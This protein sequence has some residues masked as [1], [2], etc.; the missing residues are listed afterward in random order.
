MLIDEV[1]IKVSAGNG[2]NGCVAFN[3]NLMS[4]GPV[5]ARGGN[6]GSVYFEGVSDLSALSQFRYKKEVKGKNGEDGRGQFMDGAEAGDIVLKVPMGTVITNL[7]RGTKQ[8]ITRVGQKILITKGGRGGRGNFHFKSPTN[9]TP[10]EFEYG[11][12]GQSFTLKLEMKMIADVGLVGLPNV[13]KSSLLNELT[14]AK[15]KVA[16]YHFTTL[17]PYLGD[18]FGLIIADI[19]G[20]IEGAASGKGLGDKFLKHVERTKVIFHLICVQSPHP[21]KDYEIIRKELGDYNKNLLEKKEF[22]FLSKSD[23]VDEKVLKEK[24]KALKKKNPEVT[25]LSIIDE[26]SLKAVKKIL[27]QLNQEK[28]SP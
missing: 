4:L 28:Q 19:P 24:I 20:L 22:V 3:K 7:T 12:P 26:A 10:M 5:G 25:P 15:S 17:E 2:G 18:Y 6:G 11:K 23:E 9:T 8:E 1:T 27:N 13:G 14:K 16:D 21:A